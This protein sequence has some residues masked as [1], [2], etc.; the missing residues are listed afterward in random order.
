MEFT[1]K[2]SDLVRELGLCQGVSEKKTTIPVLSNVLLEAQDD[3][4]S[5]TV[6][7]LELG[8]R[9]R[10]AAAVKKAGSTTI[11]SRKLLDYVRLLPDTELSV[12]VGEN[13]AATL[14]CGRSKTRIVGMSR[15]N[16][17]ELPSMPAAVTQIPA[18][19]LG[20]V[21]AKTIFAIASEESRYTLTGAQMLLQPDSLIMVSTDGHRLAYIR[22]EHAFDGV[23]G[24]L[25]ALLPRKAMAELQRVTAECGESDEVSFATDENHLFF[26]FDKRVLITRKLTG[27]FPDYERV[28]PQQKGR[29][30][31]L[32]KDEA[33]AAIRRVSQFADDRSHA[34]RVTLA[35]HELKL[36]SSG[37]DAGESEETMGVEYEGPPLKAGFNSLYLL[38]FLGVAETENIE[39]E[40]KDD[41][42]AGQLFLPDLRGFNYRYVVMPMKI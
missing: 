33:T 6:T 11:P 37:S 15:E 35:D 18:R 17:P 3:E 22:A 40:F 38:D 4:V 42:S 5:L 20:A 16:Y 41:E 32:N 27:Q 31:M 2:K 28:L 19:M 36:V 1:I 25:K 39:F 10:C 21:I 23:S 29:T 24:Q 13:H 8:I 14:L 7:D 12:K 26:R 30:V 9:C 34:V